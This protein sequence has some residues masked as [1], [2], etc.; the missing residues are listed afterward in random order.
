M[1]VQPD[2][3]ATLTKTAD[4]YQLRYLRDLPHERTRVWAAITEPSETV[5]WWAE[6]AVDLRVGGEFRVRWLNGDDGEPLQWLD[7]RIVEL[8]PPQGTD[9]SLIE[10][11]NEAHGVLRFELEPTPSGTR[12]VFTATSTP[13]EEKYVAMS[14]AGWHVHFEHLAAVL[15]GTVDAIDWPTWYRDHLPR[16]EVLHERYL[17]VT[18]PE[19]T[20]G[21]SA[22]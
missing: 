3:L 16:W 14:L 11:T 2:E 8:E 13:P 12:L 19:G 21:R 7:G 4:G 20:P 22:G 5:R 9:R 1:S 6:S 17:L 10:F 15:D 18:A